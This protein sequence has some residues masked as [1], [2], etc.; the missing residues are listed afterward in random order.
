MDNPISPAGTQS[1]ERD[2]LVHMLY[3]AVVDNSLWPEMVSELIEHIEYKKATQSTDR[4]YLT[5]LS[6]HFERAF[7]LSECIVNL[8]EQNATLGGVL[9]SL[10]LG[11][12]L[13][14]HADKLVYANTFASQH[15]LS[16]QPLKHLREKAL[17]AE[18]RTPEKEGTNTEL[19]SL[20]ANDD[21]YRNGVAVIPAEQIKHMTLPKNI[22]T[23]VLYSPNK[24]D[25]VINYVKRQ[26]YLTQSE[27]Q[28]LKTFYQLRNLKLAANERELTYES[29]R[30]YLKR[31]FLKTNTSDQASLISLIDTNPLSLIEINQDN[32]DFQSEIRKILTLEDG[33]QLEY[34]SL[35]PENGHVAFHFDALTGVAIDLLGNPSTYVQLLEE[36]NLR[37]VTPCRPGT[38]RSSFKAFERLTDWNEDLVALCEHLG[39]GKVSL[40]SQAFGS[41]SALAFAA[42]RPEFVK[43]A[44]L[45]APYYPNFE[46]GNWR[47]MDLFYIIANVIGKRAPKLLEVVIPFLMRSVMQNPKKYLDRHIAK[48]YCPADIDVLSSPILQSR[49][50]AML[51][52]RTALGTQGLVQENYLNTH[53][54][55]FDLSAIRCP[56]KL[57]QGAKDNLSSPD[58]TKELAELIPTA[59]L[60]LFDTLGQ[61]LL[62]SEW[63]WILELCAGITP[64]DIEQKNP[65]KAT[66]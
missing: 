43:Q 62:F 25:E 16:H 44:I 20:V 40:L 28:F 53:G 42:G 7:Q 9:N 48:S 51:G 49:I 52:E 4:E 26:Y 61:Y 38:F 46:P 8:Q 19:S 22:G 12:M 36:L 3:E 2:K 31:I 57:L 59:Q 18:K 17:P 60:T 32:A 30:T 1:V 63:P 55:D 21:V 6:E 37:I 14:D 41:C 66:G 58:A 27:S 13:Y 65:L 64:K 23:L 45:C 5:G 29:A 24:S 10:S 39:V 56:V 34:F 33:R 54:W 35:G 50:P 15:N 47:V 11:V